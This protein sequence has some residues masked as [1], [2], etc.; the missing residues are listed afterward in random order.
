[1]TRVRVL[2]PFTLLLLFLLPAACG[3][4]NQQDVLSPSHGMEALLAEEEQPVHAHLNTLIAHLFPPTDG[5]KQEAR[6]FLKALTNAVVEGDLATARSEG[7]GLVSLTLESLDAGLL[8]DPPE[9]LGFSLEE[10]VSALVNGNLKRIIPPHEPG[11]YKESDVVEVT[12]GST[13]E[14][15]Q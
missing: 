8:K 4:A 5:L 1:M 6:E 13:A 11:I 10:G 15:E 9:D 14:G 3:D 7:L 2:C 12:A